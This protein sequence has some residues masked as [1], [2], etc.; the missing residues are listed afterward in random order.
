MLLLGLCQTAP[1]IA[2]ASHYTQIMLEHSYRRR[3][4][5]AALRLRRAGGHAPLDALTDLITAE[6]DAISNQQLRLAAP[7]TGLA[8]WPLR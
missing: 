2:N 1:T 6:H 4:Q 5:T 8:R 3:V 7:A